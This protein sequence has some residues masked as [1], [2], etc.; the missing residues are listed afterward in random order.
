MNIRARGTLENQKS[1]ECKAAL[2]TYLSTGT[3]T[4]TSTA[5]LSSGVGTADYWRKFQESVRDETLPDHWDIVIRLYMEMYINDEDD[6]DLSS[7]L[8]TLPSL[9]YFEEDIPE[10][11]ELCTPFDVDHKCPNGFNRTNDVSSRQE[12]VAI[13]IFA[14]NFV[15]G[16]FCV[17]RKLCTNPRRECCYVPFDPHYFYL[18]RCGD[19][20]YATL[21]LMCQFESLT[22]T[23]VSIRSFVAERNKMYS[24]PFNPRR[25]S[26]NVL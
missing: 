7:I 8:G 13:K 6:V 23:G 25:D 20:L 1:C 14:S 22:M 24:A 19:G 21:A 16:A 12:K 10:G 26:K 3:G 11:I 15:V 5:P 4:R 2:K 18:I 17:D 9:S